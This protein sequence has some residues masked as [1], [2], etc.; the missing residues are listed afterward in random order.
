MAWVQVQQAEDLGWDAYDAVQRI[1]GEEAPA[2]MILHAAG[3]VDGRW[4]SVTVWESHEAYTSFRDS[5]LIPAVKAVF[6]EDAMQSGP[7]PE[8]WFEVKHLIQP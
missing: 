2:G 4:R 3:E 7:P 1:V 8:D 6:G 5:R